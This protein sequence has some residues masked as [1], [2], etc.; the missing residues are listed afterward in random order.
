MLQMKL[1]QLTL[2]DG[3]WGMFDP[4]AAL[5]REPLDLNIDVKGKTTLDFIGL[6]EAE[7][8]GAM[9][10]IPAPESAGHHRHLAEAWPARRWT[11]M[12]PSPS[13]TRWASRCRWARRR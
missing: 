2:S 13:T 6:M 4:G 8:T 1:T 12:A 11:P 7:E 3:V 10:P 5:K 9:P